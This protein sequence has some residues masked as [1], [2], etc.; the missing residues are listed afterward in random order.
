MNEALLLSTMLISCW[1]MLRSLKDLMKMHP[2][3]FQAFS[4]KH[5]VLLGYVYLVIIIGF[6]T[7]YIGLLL[8]GVQSVLSI[9]LNHTNGLVDIANILYFSTMTLL[10][11]GYGDIIPIGVGKLIASLQ[12]LIGYLLPA[13]FI[14]SGIIQHKE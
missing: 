1:V 6:A 10:T 9:S 5:F 4:T 12:A 13:A 14:A 3:H 11:V 8:L 7:I 2:A